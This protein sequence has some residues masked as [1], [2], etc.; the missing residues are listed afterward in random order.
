[1]R[2]TLAT[3]GGGLTGIALIGFGNVPEGGAAHF[4]THTLSLSHVNNRTHTLS[5]GG[6]SLSRPSVHDIACIFVWGGIG[7][8]D[9]KR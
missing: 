8:D 4:C 3:A 9:S 5:T 2:T 6:S 1:V 7:D